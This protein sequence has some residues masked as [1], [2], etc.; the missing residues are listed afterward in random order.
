MKYD[1]L[2]CVTLFCVFLL[3]A[4]ISCG[5]GGG[6]SSGTTS[7][8]SQV[9]IARTSVGTNGGTLEVTDPSSPL[10][11]FKLTIPENAMSQ[12][13]NI[14][15]AISDRSL[16]LPE[17]L[18]G[19]GNVISVES[20]VRKFS[21]PVSMTIPY[22]VK[23]GEVPTVIAYDNSTGSYSIPPI[24]GIDETNGRITVLT[25]HFTDFQTVIY[26]TRSLVDVPSQFNI[27]ADAFYITNTAQ[28]LEGTPHGAGACYGFAFYSKWYFENKRFSDGVLQNRYCNEKYVVSD[29]SALQYINIQDFFHKKIYSLAYLLYQKA[30][31]TNFASLRSSMI[32]KTSDGRNRPQ[33]LGLCDG[34]TCNHAV[35]ATGISY[36]QDSLGPYAEI[37]IYDSAVDSKQGIIKYYYSLDRLNYGWGP[38][39]WNRILFMGD[40]TLFSDDDGMLAI[41]NK[42]KNT[43]CSQPMTPPSTRVALA[44]IPES[45]YTEK[46]NFLVNKDYA[47]THPELP[48]NVSQLLAAIN[49]IL[50]K[51]PDNK[52]RFVLGKL[53]TYPDIAAL[54]TIDTTPAYF[55]DNNFAGNSKYGGITV[56]NW[57]SSDKYFTNSSVPAPIMNKCGFT[58]VG[59]EVASWGCFETTSISNKMYGIAYLMQATGNA[60]PLPME[61]MFNIH[62]VLHEI[63][64]TYGLG[65]PEWYGMVSSDTSG[66][67]PTLSLNYK[68]QFPLDVMGAC[69][70]TIYSQKCAF[71]PFNSWLIQ[72]NANHQL[73]V[74]VIRKA[75][76][77]MGILVKVVDASGVP[78]PNATVKVYGAVS[79]GCFNIGIPGNMA[80]VLQTAVTTTSGTT[81][82]KN[83][84]AWW[85]IGVKAS[86]NE[87]YAGAV[88]TTI[89]L[90]DAYLR[91]G[92]DTY[93]LTLTLQ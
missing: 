86:R 35:L 30:N 11:G 45:D 32:F 91:Q 69:N 60:L 39:S 31:A 44:P 89:D 8:N 28:N 56:V 92:L 21:V 9:V 23:G 25:S 12:A 46:I 77:G 41:H 76:Q 40:G 13:T 70:D 87:K 82:I 10:Y 18:T 19:K 62:T 80:T 53:M 72:H 67:M 36:K 51:D 17:A 2:W 6:S 90:E 49:A 16:A 63:G 38:Y 50:A 68:T 71:S 37:Q 47:D 20:D 81:I 57:L 54:N 22:D 75:A 42:Y 48:E 24:V 14:E 55:F 73:D 58:G 5:G 29:A 7:D 43:D 1:R 3:V 84:P 26:D 59:G 78:V 83:D 34:L 65:S 93:T 4:L 61:R 79:E 74:N 85:A 15:I 33:V 27:P 64:H 66:A 88:I 52:K